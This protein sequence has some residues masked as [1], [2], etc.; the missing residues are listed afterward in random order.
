MNDATALTNLLYIYAEL[1]DS[2]DFE[3]VAALFDHAEITVNGAVLRGGAPMLELW[4]AHTKLHE[5]GTPLT[6]HV[7]TNPIVEI[8]ADGTMA[9]IRS[10]Y[11]VLQATPVVP[12][13]VVAAGR[14]HDSFRKVDGAW[15][16]A[17]RDYS[18]LD[19]K[20]NLT[21]HLLIQPG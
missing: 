13:Q 2:G 16:F 19:L 5:D 8:G 12:L 18:L 20:G 17:T 15:R 1:M 11:T 21:D 4:R 7:V 10:Y 14:Y 9:T 6:K 3:K